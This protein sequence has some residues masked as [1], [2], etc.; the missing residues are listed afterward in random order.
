MNQ[1]LKIASLVLAFI[2]SIFFIKEKLMGENVNFD[3]MGLGAGTVK[4]LPEKNGYP[5]H[6]DSFGA[7]QILVE[8]SSKNT[9]GNKN[10]LWLGNSQLHGV[11]QY[12]D[13]QKNSVEFLYDTLQSSAISV[14]AYS[15]PNANLQEHLVVL[16]YLSSQIHLDQVVLPVFFDDTRESGLR[17]DLVSK[18]LSDVMGKSDGSEVGKALE[19]EFKSATVKEEEDPNMKALHSTTQEKVEMSLNDK[20]NNASVVWSSRADLRSKIIY[21]YIFKIR[22]SV[23]QINPDT[24]RKKIPTR[25]LINMQAFEKI[26]QFCKDSKI[27]LLVY[28]P[29]IRNDVSQPYV[30]AEYNS[31]KQELAQYEST[32]GFRLKNYEALVPAQFWGVKPSTKMGDQKFEI[33]FMHFQQEGHRLLAIEL[34]KEFINLKHK[35]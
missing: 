17:P 29:P 7:V 18:E 25:Y 31:F 2:L 10:L 9:A 12:K 13:G 30:E 15:L 35:E 28:I 11:N 24:K 14:M 21:D 3:E 5:I 32:Y 1:Y 22:N 26:A 4:Y 8:K 19:N 27:D 16:K 20:M 6:I 34:S 33:D 23:F